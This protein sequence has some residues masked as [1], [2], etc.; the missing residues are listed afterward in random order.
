[1]TDTENNR[2]WSRRF[3]QLA[4]TVASWSEDRDFQVGAVITGPGQEVRA[5]G[6]NG[7]PRGVSDG[8]ESRFDR[9]S[10]EK[11]FWIEHAERNAIYNAARVG[12]PLEGCTIHVN[13]FP[14]ADCSRAIIQSGIRHVVSPPKPVNDGALD[15]SFNVSEILL[16][17]AGVV[18][19][20]Y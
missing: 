3:R 11:F 8:D 2:S 20:S 7:L 1:M 18:L 14:C 16:S 17:E 13:R 5:T 6:Y 9:N 12:T 15:H 19:E 10:G 4:D